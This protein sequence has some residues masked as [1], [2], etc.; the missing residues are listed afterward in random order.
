ME[1]YLKYGI[2]GTG[3]MGGVIGAML[4]EAGHDVCFVAKSNFNI[5]RDSGLTIK[6][7][8]RTFSLRVNAYN[9]IEKLPKCDVLII[10]SKA[11][12]NTE[13]IP[14]LAKTLNEGGSIIVLQNGIGA[15]DKISHHI[16]H[17]QIFGGICYIKAVEIQPGVVQ[18]QGQHFV[19]LAPYK[20][21][22]ASNL[23]LEEIAKDFNS[24]GIVTKT[25][26]DLSLV[27]WSKL[28]MSI[29]FVSLSI[30]HNAK[31]HQIVTTHYSQLVEMAHEVADG[32]R[33]CGMDISPAWV[34][35]EL[36]RWKGILL[37]LPDSQPSMK[38][39]YDNKRPMEVEA[40]FYNT[41]KLAAQHGAALPMTSAIYSQLI[42]REA[43]QHAQDHELDSPLL[44]QQLDDE[45][46]KTLI[47]GLLLK[48]MDR[49]GSYPNVTLLRSNNRYKRSIISRCVSLCKQ[50]Q[51]FLY[52]L[53]FEY[54]RY[55]EE[56][57]VI[58]PDEVERE[59]LYKQI[60]M[61]MLKPDGTPRKPMN[62]LSFA[63]EIVRN[64]PD[65]GEA[66]LREKVC[67]VNT[68]FKLPIKI[69][70]ISYYPLPFAA[71]PNP[72]QLESN[73]VTDSSYASIINSGIEI[74]SASYIL[75][76][77]NLINWLVQNVSYEE[78]SD[79]LSS[80]SLHLSGLYL[81][82][83][84]EICLKLIDQHLYSEGSTLI[85]Y[86]IYED[87]KTKNITINEPSIDKNY[88]RRFFEDALSHCI[89]E[90]FFY[91]SSATKLATFQLIHE[92]VNSIFDMDISSIEDACFAICNLTLTMP[93]IP[94]STITDLEKQL[95]FERLN[96]DWMWNTNADGSRDTTSFNLRQKASILAL[97]IEEF[98]HRGLVYKAG[99]FR[100]VE[101]AQKLSYGQLFFSRN[102]G[103]IVANQPMQS[104]KCSESDIVSPQIEI[105]TYD[106]DPN[107]YPMRNSRPPFVSSLSGHAIWQ[108]VLLDIYIDKYK[109]TKSS[110]SIQNNIALFFL[111]TAALYTT[112]G[113]HSFFETINVLRLPEITKYFKQNGLAIDPMLK[114]DKE[115]LKKA[116]QESGNYVHTLCIKSM[117]HQEILN[118]SAAAQ[119]DK[120][121]RTLC[122]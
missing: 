48:A 88:A 57:L 5:I 32:A 107:S 27:R 16:N 33:Q 71:R 41:L 25:S 10:L 122:S 120:R 22:V 96:A 84:Y 60:G 100:K 113:Y 11:T 75:L 101:T 97:G 15:E 29:P 12:A 7:T 4:S 51:L 78:V 42:Q 117:N 99:T 62:V 94:W 85:K 81:N 72:H 13:L 69:E 3:A 36:A 63:D 26:N 54:Q 83:N 18:Y 79:E 59:Y 109:D 21:K 65:A 98:R 93:Q 46:K 20:G 103:P 115:T 77:I 35:R 31:F 34:D 66:C 38:D 106:R 52:P 45:S 76:T 90:S 121:S 1:R 39:D 24:S 14:K 47:T 82:L 2:V 110:E 118:H 55:I 112:N 19:T 105:V 61:L 44:P 50:H 92:I 56:K 86:A 28:V 116:V 114:L 111:L 67:F 102:T 119:V 30:R 64:I 40:I 70:D 6:S 53:F 87:L 91:S 73:L 80:L 8:D 17:D 89:V 58:S 74:D 49:A 95:C 43:A 68:F 37:T 104:Q 9:D 23:R 108:V